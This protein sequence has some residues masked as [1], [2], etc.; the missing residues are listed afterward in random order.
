MSYANNKTAYWDERRN[1][2]KTAIGQWLAG[3]DVIV[4]GRSLLRD[5]IYEI[6]EMQLLLLNITG[7]LIDADLATWIEKTRFMTAYPDARIWCNQLASFGG[8]QG[9]SP[10]A[11]GVLGF[12]AADSKAY[13]SKVQMHTVQT[14]K[15]LYA[16]SQQGQSFADM[17]SAFPLRQGS[18]S[19]PGFSRPLRVE[20]E[21]LK[22]MRQ[23][24]QDMGFAE[25]SHMRFVEQLS[26]Y[27]ETHYQLGMNVA[28]YCCAFLIDNGFSA[29]EVYLISVRSVESGVLACYV[30]QRQQPENSFL[31]LRCADIAYRGVAIRHLNKSLNHGNIK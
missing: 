28:G 20:D 17:L 30:D 6:S 15:A 16:F 2:V 3:D 19:I 14:I 5:L 26:D 27:L 31:P 22:P 23:L 8:T 4:R 13:G 1:R 29:E 11:A 12:L 25:G 9:V 24:T 10:V 18:P 7:R 21:R